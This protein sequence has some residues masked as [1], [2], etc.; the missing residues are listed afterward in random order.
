MVTEQALLRWAD[1]RLHWDRSAVA[2]R[3]AVGAWNAP[4]VTMGYRYDSSAI[5]DPLLTVP[6]TEDVAASLDGAPGSHLWHQW[7]GGLSTLDLIGPGF[8]VLSATAVW[9]HAASGLDLPVRRL[10]RAWAESVGIGEACALL[11][12][13]DG[14][15]AWRS[16]GAATERLGDVLRTIT[17]HKPRRA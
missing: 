9:D 16:V 15:I 6:S 11:V 3:A 12:R 5:I 7:I 1:P 13:P 17:S 14:F 10:D 8:T 4:M 2:E